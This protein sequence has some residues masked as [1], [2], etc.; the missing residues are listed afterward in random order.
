MKMHGIIYCS[1]LGAVFVGSIGCGTGISPEE[2]TLVVEKVSFSREIQPLFDTPLVSADGTM[3]NNVACIFCHSPA[4]PITGSQTGQS[5]CGSADVNDGDVRCQDRANSA[6]YVSPANSRGA[7]A[8][9]T[10]S[11]NTS[12][13]STSSAA[14]KFP[15]GP[16]GNSFTAQKYFSWANGF[17]KNLS[18]YAF[19]C[20]VV[21]ELL[22]LEYD[23]ATATT[24]PLKSM[25]VAK[26]KG[27]MWDG[28]ALTTGRQMPYN[29][30]ASASGTPYVDTDAARNEVTFTAA[31]IELLLKWYSE[32][33]D[34]TN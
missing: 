4:E 32:G 16:A 15:K 25:L 10:L 20:T 28:S 30:T 17:S 26:L 27:V 8:A 31:Q 18:G 6:Y 12:F 13:S 2:E 1:V 19:N 24:D 3:A 11:F 9:L 14:V 22:E 7:G 33:A 34:C 21:K 5:F 29:A 23:G